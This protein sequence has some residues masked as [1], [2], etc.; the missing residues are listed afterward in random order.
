MNN[1]ALLDCLVDIAF[2]S[3]YIHLLG[4]AGRHA[5]AG[6][7][8]DGKQV[9][10]LRARFVQHVYHGGAAVL[11]A[12][13]GGV[14]FG[15]AVYQHPLFNDGRTFFCAESNKTKGKI[16]ELAMPIYCQVQTW[17]RRGQILNLGKL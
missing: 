7:R 4:V 13:L 14:F 6:L 10:A 2:I 12:E 3:K 1:S 9:G 5:A 15:R 11:D 8:L 17:N 16:S